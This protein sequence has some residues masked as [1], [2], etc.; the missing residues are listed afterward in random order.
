MDAKK[1]AIEAELKVLAAA[2]ER[3]K[4]LAGWDW[5]LESVNSLSLP[6]TVFP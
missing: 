3:L 1:D 2:P 5:V 6:N 4:S